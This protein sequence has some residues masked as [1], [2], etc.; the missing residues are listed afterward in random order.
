MASPFS[1]CISPAAGFCR[2]SQFPTRNERFYHPRCFRVEHV[3]ERQ[4][5]ERCSAVRD[6]APRC[7]GS[8]TRS[9]ARRTAARTHRTTPHPDRLRP[10]GRR[11]GCQRVVVCRSQQGLAI[12]RA[13]CFGL[14]RQ[15]CATRY[16]AR[17][18]KRNSGH[19]AGPASN[20]ATSRRLHLAGDGRDAIRHRIP[21][22]THPVVTGS[23][24]RRTG[25][26]GSGRRF[27][28]RAGA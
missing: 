18:K 20:P 27:D 1:C 17:S 26:T 23:A 14:A 22:R 9:Q 2:P 19:R 24:D 28:L 4:D 5:E 15:G 25:I 21:D 7:A 6:S 11:I 13:S 10:P 3:A 16:S 8:R 12:W